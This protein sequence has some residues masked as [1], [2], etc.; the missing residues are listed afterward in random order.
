MPNHSHNFKRWIH[1]NVFSP[2][3][4]YYGIPN[5]G[6]QIDESTTPVGNNKPHNIMQPSI[7]MKFYIKAK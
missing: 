1:G 5:D 3:G 2:K 7:F 6:H 4:D